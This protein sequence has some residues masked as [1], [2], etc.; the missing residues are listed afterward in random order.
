MK[1]KGNNNIFLK[2]LSHAFF[3]TRCPSC[4]LAMAFGERFCGE[5]EKMIY[6]LKGD[7][8]IRC[9]RQKELCV[10]DDAPPSYDR[11]IAPFEYSGAVRRGLISLKKHK[12]IDLAAFF[13]DKIAREALIKYRN[14]PFDAVV[15]VPM[16]DKRLKMRG[17]NQS[18]LIAARVAK[19]LDLPLDDKLLKQT[20]ISETQ[21]KLS[22]FMR[23]ENVKGIYS[24]D[25]GGK[26][27]YKNVLLIDDIITSGA[28]MN[29]CA[30]TLKSA[31]VWHVYGA[32]AA[33][34]VTD[35]G[36]K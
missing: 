33:K 3:P 11:L 7:L 27:P 31:G 1:N 26:V 14:I 18:E 21:H 16:H 28:T 36:I 22:F 30:K 8:C 29:E 34:T 23:L 25:F 2:Y 12:D 32:G 10:C 9:L 19:M 20:K 17:Y 24:A 15:A 4:D 35:Y 5:C 6:P 13:G